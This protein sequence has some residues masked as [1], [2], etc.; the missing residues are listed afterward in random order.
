MLKVH[1]ILLL[2]QR[3]KLHLHENILVR[4]FDSSLNNISLNHHEYLKLQFAPVVTGVEE[5]FDAGDKA[6]VVA[7]MTSP[8]LPDNVKPV[9][10]ALYDKYI[11]LGE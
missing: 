11:E 6:K 2:F 8:Y 1:E 5:A 7:I 3:D 10:Q 9:A 4:R